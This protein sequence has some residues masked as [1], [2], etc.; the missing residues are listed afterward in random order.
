[1]LVAKSKKNFLVKIDYV[2]CGFSSTMQLKV[3][4]EF[5]SRTGEPVYQCQ[6]KTT[7]RSKHKTG[8][9]NQSK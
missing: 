6:C 7:K 3:K 9:V 2:A 8:Q 1:M 4:I 5:H